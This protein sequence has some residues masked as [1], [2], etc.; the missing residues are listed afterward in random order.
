MNI[1]PFPTLSPATI[2]A[3]NVI[4]QWLAQDDFSGEVPYQ[5]DCV[6]LAGNAVMPTIDAACKIARD[7]QIPLLISGGI[8]HSPTFLY[9]AIAQHPHYNT[10]RTTGRAEATILAVS[11]ISS[12]I[13]RMKKSGL[14]TSQQ[15]AVKTHALASRY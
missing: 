5:A 15:T 6:I 11:L 10:I 8:G 1:T 12:G 2:D 13:F 14:K 7:Q 3:I 4:G 9:S